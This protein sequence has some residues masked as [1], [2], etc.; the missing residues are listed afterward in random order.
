MAKFYSIS[1]VHGYAFILYLEQK[2]KSITVLDRQ[3]IDY[4]E[5]AAYCKNKK[6]L[7]ISVEQKFEFSENIQV[8]VAIATSRNVK[9]Y[10]FYKVKEANPNMDVLF[11]FKKLPKQNDEEN[12][13]YTVEAL[14][15]K[16]YL[17]A[18]SFV[19]DFSKIKSAT[20][21][22]F[23]LLSLANKCINAE[24]YICVYTHATTVLVLAVEQKE[25][26][27]SR[28]TTIELQ[29]PETMQ[30]DI[31]ENITQTISYISNQFRDVKFQTLVLSGSIAL[32]DVIAQHIA[33][34][35]NLN[36]SILYP[37]TFIQNINA[38]ESQE[39]ILSLGSALVEKPNQF[40][41]KLILGIQ[42]FNIIATV[43]IVLS[44]ILLSFMIYFTFTRYEDYSNLIQQNKVLKN[45][46][47]S[48]L[49]HT[50]MLPKEELKKYKYNIYMTKTYLKESFIDKIIELKPLISLEKPS[51][52]EYKN[53]KGSIS[54]KVSFE[55]KFG[56]LVNLYKF[57]K[58]FDSRFNAIKEKL[59]I[60]KKT[61]VDYKQLLY[62]TEITT[63]KEKL[64]N[65]RQRARRQ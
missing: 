36:I 8:P 39:H 13:T 15:K 47:L 27:F 59:K 17:E 1:V 63:I 56:E 52:F 14:D 61:T 38:E 12:I 45:R 9:N 23:S 20:T 64:V 28:V 57:E 53:E 51:N 42:Q 4:D 49:S 34:F 55:K 41:P 30:M 43:G 19:D 46:Y 48:T 21:S 16:A 3:E 5:L 60:T 22:K 24:Y 32:D 26:I 58:E 31:A 10:L 44:S 6:N 65:Q 62:K 35:N 40:L 11:N 18:L 7:H 29:A 37:K 50:K 2:N 33:M 25:L 54:L